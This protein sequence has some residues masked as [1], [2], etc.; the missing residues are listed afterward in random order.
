[1]GE[2]NNVPLA[3]VYAHQEN[4][5][6]AEEIPVNALL[7]GSSTEW[8]EL[9]SGV[10]A[11]GWK[12]IKMKAPAT[13]PEALTMVSQVRE[14]VG[15]LVKLRMD[16]NGGWTEEQTHQFLA[17]AAHLDLE[18]IEQPLPPDELA[19]SGRLAQKNLDSNCP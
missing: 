15:S 13:V 16:V 1:M 17:Q 4:L 2:K 14:W 18:Y 5:L 8:G 7:A 11:K 12:T 6:V 9:A 19:A 3:Q 10:V